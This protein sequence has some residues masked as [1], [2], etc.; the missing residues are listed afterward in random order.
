[1][2]GNTTH[3][4][5]QD[6]VGPLQTRP[7]GLEDELWVSTAGHHRGSRGTN[8]AP[9]VYKDII[10]HTTSFSKELSFP[11]TLINTQSSAVLTMTN[12]R[13]ACREKVKAIS[14]VT[15][16]GGLSDFETNFIG[17][18]SSFCHDDE[19]DEDDFITG[20]SPGSARIKD[21]SKQF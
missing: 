10:V 1:M 19:D 2:R 20:K 21:N 6:G 18:V 14:H 7:S 3:T 9:S 8:P 4:T 11:S 13:A 15:S 17:K 12:L 5:G 16:L